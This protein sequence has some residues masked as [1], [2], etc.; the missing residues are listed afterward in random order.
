MFLAAT[1]SKSSLRILR[2]NFTALDFS[3]LFSPTACPK[4]AF[5][6]GCSEECRCIQQNALECHRR[7]GTCV[8][9]PG[10]RGSTCKDGEQPVRFLSSSQEAKV[11]QL[12]ALS[13]ECDPGSFG[14]GCESRCTCPPGVSCHHVTGECQR[15]CPVGRHGGDCDQGTGA[16][17]GHTT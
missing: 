4:W 11:K 10:Y 6:P 13:V 3:V 17:R 7:H 15:K 8:C 16:H 2:S 9:K 12:P 14:H 1:G 5:G